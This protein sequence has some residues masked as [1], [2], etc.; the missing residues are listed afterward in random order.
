MWSHHVVLKP[1]RG[2]QKLLP[3]TRLRDMVLKKIANEMQKNISSFF[4]HGLLSLFLALVLPSA[5]RSQ[6]GNISVQT[7]SVFCTRC[8]TQNAD[9]ST[10]T[11]GKLFAASFLVICCLIPDALK[12]TL[13]WRCTHNQLIRRAPAVLWKV[14]RGEQT[15]HKINSQLLLLSNCNVRTN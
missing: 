9:H 8:K 5:K 6:F 11:C 12:C 4:Y 3:N 7:T 13:N 10:T 14:Y 15:Q 1:H 2:L